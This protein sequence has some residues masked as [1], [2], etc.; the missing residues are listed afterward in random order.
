MQNDGSIGIDFGSDYSVEGQV[1]SLRLKGVSVESTM[2]DRNI[3][4]DFSMSL[5]DGCINDVLSGAST[6]DDFAYNIAMTGSLT[7]PTPTFT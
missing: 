3:Q 1:W 7:V 5:I 4:Y 2:A 6:I